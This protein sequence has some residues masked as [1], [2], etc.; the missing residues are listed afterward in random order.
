MGLSYVHSLMGLSYLPETHNIMG[1]SYL[2]IVTPF[3]IIMEMSY[4]QLQKEF[5]GI[6]PRPTH[7]T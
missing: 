2:A 1:P 6:S 5:A 7:F 4:M 3:Y